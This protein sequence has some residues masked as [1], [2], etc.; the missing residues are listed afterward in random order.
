MKKFSRKR[1][2]CFLLALFLICTG[3]LAVCPTSTYATESSITGHI[4]VMVNKTPEE[5]QKY[6][7]MFQNRYPGV[8]VSYIY[9]ENYEEQALEQMKSGDYADVLFIPSSISSDEYGQYLEVLGDSSELSKKYN[10]MDQAKQIGAQVYGIPSFAY[11]SGFLYNKAVFQKAGITEIPKTT[12]DFLSALRAIKDY[13]DATPFYTNYV[14]DWALNIWEI[15]PFIDMTGDADYRKNIFVNESNPYNTDSTH[16]TVYRLL[17]DIVKEQLCEENVGEGDWEQSKAML[18]QGKIGCIAIGSWALT[19]FKH[20]GDQGDDVSFMPFPNEID[21]KQYSTISTDYCYGVNCHSQNKEAAKAYV[22]F[23]LN[24]SG[25]A[26]DMDTISIVKTDP[27]P[28]SY[29]EMNDVVMLTTSSATTE[30]KGKY[31]TLA[32]NL[33]LTD[34]K[35]QKRIM[36][37]AAGKSSET[38]D[39]I[40]EDWNARWESSRTSDMKTDNDILTFSQPKLE[41][42]KYTVTFSDSENEY[43]EKH[44]T[45]RVGYLRNYAPFEY[46]Q[47]GKFCGVAAELFQII[48]KQT[49]ITFRYL[50]FDNFSQMSD[51]I[52]AS[53]GLPGSIDI[54]AGIEEI[55]AFSDRLRLSKE[56]ASFTN[57]LVKNQH[58]QIDD[59]SKKTAVTVVGDEFDYFKGSND[60]TYENSLSETIHQVNQMNADYTITNYYTASYYIREG[61]YNNVTML[62]MTSKNGMYLGFGRETDA[63]LIAIC[64]KCIY[65]IPSYR[66]E[67]LLLD[68]MDP[69]AEHITLKS[70]IEIYPLYSFIALF[71]LFTAITCVIF[72]V[73]R[74][75]E[76]STRNLAL[77]AK[78]YQILS[79]ITDEYVFEYNG[80]QNILLFDPKFSDTFTFGGEVDLDDYDQSNN[81]L[82]LFLD[83]FLAVKEDDS[84]NKAPFLFEHNDG[85]QVWYRLV[86][87]KIYDEKKQNIIQMIGKISNAQDEMKERQ[88]ILHKAD[89]DPL[90]GLYNR[91][92]FQNAFQRYRD[93]QKEPS[94][95][96]FA[97]LDLD[98]FKSVNDT[99]GHAGGDAALELLGKKLETIFEDRGIVARYGGDEFIVCIP[100]LTDIME[101]DHLFHK[102]VSRMDRLLIYQQQK[103]KLSISLGA[104]VVD[105]SI[106]YSTALKQADAVLYEVK[107]AGKN[108]YK[109]VEK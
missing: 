101:A 73:Y 3:I 45:L 97:I 81:E 40:F 77:A 76:K 42:D 60:V 95:Y 99:L 47:D 21:G 65:S 14:S 83:Q 27:Y 100:E 61:R 71:L 20:A 70:L 13:T 18:N 6:K 90:T 80:V 94:R 50:A 68:N 56:Y 43:L 23:M 79:D 49:G 48:S 29:S 51:G 32:S 64:N 85:R 19:Q 86:V 66:M 58:T 107:L 108:N 17:Y 103:K 16:G 33:N 54:I 5:M 55:S 2:I 22:D 8:D 82:N 109:I 25:Y 102:L 104:V 38:L 59:L 52:N 37:A 57:V 39:D 74:E 41:S 63:R 46:E 96:A 24:E 67:M 9:Y 30:N 26:L 7:E 91:E 87:S 72:W 106:D 28:D 84:K 35:E 31:E 92:G 62:P 53:P 1:T 98:N 15:Y 105:D 89:R 93:A 11:V 44:K 75:K 4:D 34:G 69:P 12:T 78:R 88:R 10:Y 36:D